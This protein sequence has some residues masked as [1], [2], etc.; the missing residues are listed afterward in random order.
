VG[1]WEA[2][3]GVTQRGPGHL[4]VMLLQESY[5]SGSGLFPGLAQHPSDGFMDEVVLIGCQ[6]AARVGAEE[7]AERLGTI[8]YEVVCG[9]SARVP[10]RYVHGASAA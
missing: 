3:D 10:R 9:I 4:R 6:G 7:W 8:S 2:L 5:Q 1:Q